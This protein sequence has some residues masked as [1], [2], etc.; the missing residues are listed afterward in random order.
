M[1]PF[2]IHCNSWTFVHTLLRTQT[3]FNHWPLRRS[4]HI[5]CRVKGRLKLFS[6]ASKLLWSSTWSDIAKICSK[7]CEA[8]PVQLEIQLTARIGNTG[9]VWQ[10]VLLLLF[11]THYYQLL[12]VTITIHLITSQFHKSMASSILFSEARALEIRNPSRC[13]QADT[14]GCNCYNWLIWLHMITPLHFNTSSYT[15]TIC[16]RNSARSRQR[17]LIALPLHMCHEFLPYSE[18]H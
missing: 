14:I 9:S 11:T 3:P 15:A 12:Q 13:E 2:R 18:I 4:L 5:D 8:H 7:I 1:I 10:R 17:N 16:W 6:Q